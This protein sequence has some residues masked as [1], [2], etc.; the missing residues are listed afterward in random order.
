MC[1]CPVLSKTN[2]LLPRGTLASDT[3]LSTKMQKGIFNLL[4]KN[5][6]FRSVLLTLDLHVKCLLHIKH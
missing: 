2:K 4:Y 3:K 1:G 6:L 5:S